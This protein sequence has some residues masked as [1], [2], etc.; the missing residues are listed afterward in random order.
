MRTSTGIAI[1]VA[2]GLSSCSF[3]PPTRTQ[4]QE[5]VVASPEHGPVTLTGSFAAVD[6]NFERKPWRSPG[7][8]LASGEGY[9]LAVE[10]GLPEGSTSDGA[11]TLAAQYARTEH[12]EIRTGTRTELHLAT[13]MVCSRPWEFGG[14][15]FAIGPRLCFGFGVMVADHAAGGPS[16]DIAA[17][18]TVG[19]DF[20]VRVFRHI[21]MHAG[22]RLVYAG[23]PGDTVATGGLMFVGGGIRF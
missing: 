4:N 18:A 15:D 2:I 20:G 12:A 1:V 7:P 23:F 22:G 5:P 6:L 10:T 19:L 13:A 8:D 9:A 14:E 21:V 16:D 11:V 17:T 3:A